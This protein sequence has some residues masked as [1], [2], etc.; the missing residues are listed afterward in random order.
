[1]ADLSLLKSSV[2]VPSGTESMA[3]FEKTLAKLNAKAVKYGLS[4]V[5]AGEAVRERFA[6]RYEHDD[7]REVTRM[8]V[9]PLGDRQPQEGD[10][11]LYLNRIPLEYPIIALGSW[12]VLGKL[13]PFGEGRIAF[14][15]SDDPVENAQLGE[16]REAEPCCEHCNKK[17]QR[18]DTYV[19]RHAD[20][21]ERWL[22]R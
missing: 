14:A 3:G 21:G 16:Y 17:R 18:K 5:T 8:Y 13:E 11:V 19:V 10:E 7:H 6:R 1:M 15:A 12:K 9:V 20:T 22:A 4:P 2:L